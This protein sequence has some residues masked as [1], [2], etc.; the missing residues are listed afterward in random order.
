MDATFI[1]SRCLRHWIADI[2]TP[3][4]VY[5][6]QGLRT[7]TESLLRAFSDYPG[8]AVRFPVRM[9]P[10]PAVLRVLR[11][12]GCGVECGNA[13]ELALAKDCGFH[14]QAVLYAPVIPE[15]PG[16]ALAME[17]DAAW[18]VHGPHTLPPAP[19]KRLYLCCS[20]EN[21]LVSEGTRICNVGRSKFGMDADT[22]REV[23]EQ[24]RESAQAELGLAFRAGD[25]QLRPNLAPAVLRLLLEQ[26]ALLKEKAGV[27]IRFFDW[28]GCPGIRHP[29]GAEAPNVS[30]LA[31]RLSPLL[32]EANGVSLSLTAGRFLAARAG[33]LLTRVCAVVPRTR[34]AIYADCS[35]AQFPRPLLA[36]P[37]PVSVMGKKS[38]TGR[39]L[40]DIFG[41]LPDLRDRLAERVLLPPVK[42]GDCLIIHN[43]GADGFSM[44][45]R[46]GGMPV[47]EEYLFCEDGSF[48]RI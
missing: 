34:S 36:S 40:A 18:L 43:T 32:A 15:Q 19:P 5:D 39:Q 24:Y 25:N 37:H 47:C 14:G 17:L 35:F 21:A 42:P 41:C 12:A 48:R 29:D 11:E 30:T 46:Y 6:A 27:H 4:Y 9:N 1:P 23:A 2:P 8:F 22:L 44:S 26:A 16:Q 38:E 33:I 20:P 7:Q 10:N 28:N 13:A 3:C 31:A 45:S